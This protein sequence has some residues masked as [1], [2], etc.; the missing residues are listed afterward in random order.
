MGVTDCHV[1]INPVWEMRPEARALLRHE[2]P[3]AAI[4]RY[5]AEP[6]AFLANLDRVGVDRPLL[7]NYVS[8]DVVRY[9]ARANDFVLEYCRGHAD[10][11]L[12]VGGFRPDHPD[13]EGVIVRL[14]RAGLRA[15]K[16]HPPHQLFAPNAYRVGDG[17]ALGRIYGSCERLG[18]PVIFHTGTSVFPRAR[19]R[20]G[21]PILVEDVAIDF[22][23]LPII[24]AHGGR[25]LWMS[26]AVF[27]VRRFPQVYL[28]LSSIPP[29]RLLSYFPELERMAEKVLFG[30][31][32]PGP[33]VRDI[34]EN[35]AACRALGLSAPALE[36]ILVDNALALFPPRPP[37]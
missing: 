14:C 30:S 28:D 25:P 17:S 16:L 31:D 29:V 11:L 10:R 27:L 37:G 8:P 18:L 35:L 4:E 7:I 3:A 23:K 20:F 32:W 34:G 36:R 2:G 13:P 6:E 21:E 19:N 15:L 26:Q 22:P 33:G 9:T 12:P 24:L 1:H 5:L